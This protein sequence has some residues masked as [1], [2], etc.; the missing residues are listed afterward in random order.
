MPSVQSLKEEYSELFEHLKVDNCAE[1]LALFGFECSDG[2]YH[3]LA[4]LFH[5]V[6]TPYRATLRTIKYLEE[7]ISKLVQAND[8]PE[9]LAKLQG[10]LIENKDTA[11]FQKKNLLQPVQIK[12]KYGTLRIYCDNNA[13]ETDALISFAEYMSAVTCELCGK[14]G[15]LISTG[16]HCVRCEEHKPKQK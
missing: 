6:T 2:W 16:W 8:D 11:E 10:Y 12:E 9:Q 13:P 3:I 5:T 1:P 7:K 4:G 15:E 14:P